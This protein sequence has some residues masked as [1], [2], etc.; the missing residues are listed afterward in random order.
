MDSPDRLCGQRN[1]SAEAAVGKAAKIG[2]SR[3]LAKFGAVIGVL[4]FVLVVTSVTRSR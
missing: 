3:A 2:R 4:A 1:S